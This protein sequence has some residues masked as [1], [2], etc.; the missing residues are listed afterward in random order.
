MR[1]HVHALRMHA[2]QDV[3]PAPASQ[4]R[5]HRFTQIYPPETQDAAQRYA[6]VL[7]VASD[8]FPDQRCQC[9]YCARRRE[10]RLLRATASELRRCVCGG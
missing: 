9:A 5:V 10:S 1:E 8:A 2:S 7:G 4:V 3:S 6:R